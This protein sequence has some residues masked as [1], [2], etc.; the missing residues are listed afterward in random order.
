MFMAQYTEMWTAVDLIAEKQA[1]RGGRRQQSA[2][3]DL[4]PYPDGDGNVLVMEGRY[5][6]YVKYGK[7]NATLPKGKDP[8]SVTLEEAVGFIAEKAAKNG[9]GKPAG[10]SAAK[11]PSAK[12]P[13]AKNKPAAGKS[14]AKEKA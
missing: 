10:K 9:G 2:L 13:A 6:P 7:V 5:G 14:A 3:K 11:K 1:S 4:G 12:K 8:M